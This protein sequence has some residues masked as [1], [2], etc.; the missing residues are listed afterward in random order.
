MPS[1]C[2]SLET[3]MEELFIPP[4]SKSRKPKAGSNQLSKIYYGKAAASEKAVW[5][6]SLF[7]WAFGFLGQKPKPKAQPN[8]PSACSAACIWLISLSLSAN[9]QYF[10]L[11]PNQPA[12]L[13]AMA[14]KSI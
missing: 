4:I 2:I 10:S 12:A 7:G 5:K 3:T 14:Y 6:N 9:E 8:A 1:I 13:S 11:T